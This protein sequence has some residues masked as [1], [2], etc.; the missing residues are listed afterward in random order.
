MGSGEIEPPPRG[1]R[2]APSPG[3]A[4][5]LERPVER[6]ELILWALMEKFE[7]LAIDRYARFA[8]RL[9]TDEKRRFCARLDALVVDP[10]PL[11]TSELA[12]PVEELLARARSADEIATLIVQGLVL[13]NLGQAIYRVA[14]HTERASAVSRDVAEEGR[15]ACASVTV[16]AAARIAE[17]VGTH[18]RLYASFADGSYDVLG[19]L[20]ALAEPVDLVFGER[21]GLRFAD[22]LG[23][24][25]ADL[26]TTCTALGLQR[27]KVV[28]HLAGACMGL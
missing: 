25:A 20:D 11:A 13:E 10:E 23:E 14:A 1:A 4:A 16:V 17:L 5:S 8:P 22:V 18:E 9:A 3:A 21:Y 19:A 2:V 28:A 26:I 15:A 12:G 7:R 24:F 27:R 6:A